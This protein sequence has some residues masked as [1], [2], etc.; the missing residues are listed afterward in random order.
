MPTVWIVPVGT[1][2]AD[3]AA[4]GDY[5]LRRAGDLYETG[6]KDTSCT[7]FGSLSA[8]LLPALPDVDAPEES[9]EQQVVLAA[10]QGVESA[11]ALRGG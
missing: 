9:P 5:L 11:E 3:A 7:W 8:E 1:D 6:R 2:T 10:V 4:S